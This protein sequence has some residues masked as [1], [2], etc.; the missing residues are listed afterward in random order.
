MSAS[1]IKQ[2]PYWEVEG[3]W[4]T[5]FPMLQRAINVAPDEWNLEAVYKKLINPFDPAPMQLWYCESKFALVTQI[6]TFPAGGRKCLLFLCGGEDL[7][8]LRDSKAKVAHWAKRYMGCNKL[9]IYGRR[10]FLRALPDFYEVSTIM[11]SN[12]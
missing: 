12:I 5:V 8:A 4:P 10:G 7:Q 11:E 6:Q 3:M 2:I 9:I 1:E